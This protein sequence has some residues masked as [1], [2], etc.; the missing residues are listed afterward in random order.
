[1]Q[2]QICCIHKR[3]ICGQMYMDNNQNVYHF[4]LH[5]KFSFTPLKLPVKGQRHRE[6]LSALPL[7]LW[8]TPLPT[9]SSRT[10]GNVT[11]TK[12]HQRLD[13]IFFFFYPHIWE[14]S[15]FVYKKN[16]YMLYETRTLKTSARWSHRIASSFAWVSHDSSSFLVN[17]FADFP[18]VVQVKK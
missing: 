17:N 3:K 7:L 6:T 15:K 10:I 11:V 16:R 18:D 13:A 2:I 14:I 4:I 1:M 9:G 8:L 5:D 12:R